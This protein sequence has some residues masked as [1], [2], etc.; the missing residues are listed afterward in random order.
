MELCNCICFH[1]QPVT[2][3]DLDAI[4]EYLA[5]TDYTESNHNLVN[6]VEWLDLYPLFIHKEE[7]F[8]ILIGI[9]HDEYFM[10][11][12]L[13]KKEHFKKALSK[14]K[15]ILDAC[16]VR[17]TM[18]CFTKEYKDLVLELYP[19]LQVTDLRDGYDYLYD[20]EKLRTFSGKQLQKKRNLINNFYKNYEGRYRYEDLSHENIAKVKEFVLSLEADTETLYV[21][22]AG[23]LLVLDLFEKLEYKGG[24]IFIDDQVEAMIIASK[25]ND[26]MIQENIEKADKDIPGLY[27][28][29]MKEFFS[30]NYLEATCINREDDMGLEDLRYSKLSYRPI[31]FI[32]KYYLEEL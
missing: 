24:V 25:L 22:R 29:M 12:P 30:R 7:D 9:Y 5:Y 19:H 26:Q 28:V 32:E 23:I 17:F 31:G 4:E 16:N 15:T 6:M 18:S 3:F 8:I 10:Y 27:Q 11:M 20:A 13:C 2:L 21:E 14:A 1:F